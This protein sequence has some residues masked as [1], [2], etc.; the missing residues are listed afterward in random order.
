MAGISGGKGNEAIVVFAGGGH[1]F[2]EGT[3]VPAQPV[4]DGRADIPGPIFL[5]QSTVGPIHIPNK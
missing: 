2:A 4:A 5:G 1:S 3:V